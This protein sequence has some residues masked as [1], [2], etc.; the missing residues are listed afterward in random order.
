[1]TI[2]LSLTTFSEIQILDTAIFPFYANCSQSFKLCIQEAHMKIRFVL[3]L[4]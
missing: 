2:V 1:M 3:E 4:S